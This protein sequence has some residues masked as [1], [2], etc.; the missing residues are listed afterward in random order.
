MTEDKCK[1]LMD[2]AATH[3]SAKIRY[4]TSDMILRVDSDA[5]YL[6]LPQARSRGTVYFY[7]ISNPT[8]CNIIPSPQDNGPI[9]TECVTLKN[10]VPSV[11]DVE[12]DTLH[13]N[14]KTAIPIRT[15][16]QKLEH[17][18]GPTASKPTKTP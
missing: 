4:H 15:T 5:A 11:A 6:V 2:Y 18:Q 7:L 17:P 3:L 12:A 16:L 14:G 8:S 10:V 13:H 1:M 9:L